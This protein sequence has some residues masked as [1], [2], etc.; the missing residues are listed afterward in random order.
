MTEEERIILSSY[1]HFN[2]TRQT[3]G[4]ALISGK[5]GREYFTKWFKLLEPWIDSDLQEILRCDITKNFASAEE[6]VDHI[7]KSF[8]H[9]LSTNKEINSLINPLLL[10]RIKSDLYRKLM[11]RLKNIYI[12]RM[13]TLFFQQSHK[14]ISPFFLKKERGHLPPEYFINQ[15][16]MKKYS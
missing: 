3:L 4:P 2:F 12:K 7:Y 13:N 15:E 10:R 6:F 14:N 16:L 1:F 11:L 5:F 8:L 9:F